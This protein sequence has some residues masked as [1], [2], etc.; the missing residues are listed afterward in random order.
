MILQAVSN[1]LL[2]SLHSIVVYVH[3]FLERL[4]CHILDIV[5]FIH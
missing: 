4:E 5:F 3:Y 1:C 2:V